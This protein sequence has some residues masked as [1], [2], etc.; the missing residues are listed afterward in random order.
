MALLALQQAEAGLKY[1]TMPRIYFEAFLVKL[2]HFRKIV[3]LRELIKDVESLKETPQ[4]PAARTSGAPAKDTAPTGGASRPGPPGGVP[5][6]SQASPPKPEGPSG[7]DIFSRVLEKLAADR[8][9]LAALLG[10][11]SSVMVRDNAL[12]V[13]FASGR[14]FFVTS[15]QEKDVRAVERA[16]SEVLGRDI[17]V[18]F[19]EE[20]ATGGGPIK[21]GR[22]LESAMKDPAVQFFMNTFKAQVLSADPVPSPRDPGPKGRGPAE[23]ES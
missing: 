2:C 15:I 6:A 5:P 4:R 19:A 3:P 11:Y 23:N 9:P 18:H 10:Q 8:A 17:K 12:E 13:F 20:S 7:K 22:E 14:G 16:A 1:S 21:P